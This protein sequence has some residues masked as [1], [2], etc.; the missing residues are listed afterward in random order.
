MTEETPYESRN[1]YSVAATKREKGIPDCVTVLHDH[2]AAA[3]L[4]ARWQRQ[5]FDATMQERAICA[6]CAK[7]LVYVVVARKRVD[8]GDQALADLLGVDKDVVA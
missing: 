7:I 8:E 2:I 4:R 5:G 3:E 1:G 6:D